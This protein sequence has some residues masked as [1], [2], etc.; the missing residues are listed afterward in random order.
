MKTKSTLLISCDLLLYTGDGFHF[1]V[2]ILLIKVSPVDYFVLL[3]QGNE[4]LN[5]EMPERRTDERTDGKT[6]RQ[7]DEGEAQ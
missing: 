2:F 6:D 4:V 1:P 5:D 3:L 7:T